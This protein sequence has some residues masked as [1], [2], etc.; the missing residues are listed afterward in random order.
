ME[1]FSTLLDMFDAFGFAH[2]VIDQGEPQHLGIRQALEQLG[3]FAQLFFGV[4][5]NSSRKSTARKVCSSTVYL[6]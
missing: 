2:I 6:W 3:E 4:S 1:Q 5:G